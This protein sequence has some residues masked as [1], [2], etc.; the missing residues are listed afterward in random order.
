VLL[1]RKD[2][3]APKCPGRPDIAVYDRHHAGPLNRGR[4]HSDKSA[5][6]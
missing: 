2:H 1:R 5:N 6:I 4:C 3:T